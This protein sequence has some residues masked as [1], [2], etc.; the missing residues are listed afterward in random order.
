MDPGR[1]ERR[2]YL[3]RPAWGSTAAA[4][5]AGPVHEPTSGAVGRP[6]TPPTGRVRHP[7]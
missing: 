6:S 2:E 7:P 4:R 1:G 5:G 3:G